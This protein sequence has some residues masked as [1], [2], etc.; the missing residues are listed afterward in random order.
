MDQDVINEMICS[1]ESWARGDGGEWVDLFGEDARGAD[2]SGAKIPRACFGMADLA[3]VDFSG[4]DLRDAD[5]QGATCSGADFSKADLR[6]AKFDNAYLSGADFS[7]ADLKGASICGAGLWGTDFRFADLRGASIRSSL[8]VMPEMQGAKIEG[9]DLPYYERCPS[10]GV[11][12]AWTVVEGGDILDIEIP[13]CARRTSSLHTRK[14][15]ADMVHVIQGEGV[16]GELVFKEGETVV[17][18]DYSE[19]IRKR[20]GRIQFVMS[21]RE[22][23]NWAMV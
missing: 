21:R 15:R 6:G 18:D 2:F 5:F 14:C 3:G 10:R 4:A 7:R 16:V 8:H 20:D 12:R 19:D 23:Q 22:A 11:F 9:A 1:H 17:A 13:A